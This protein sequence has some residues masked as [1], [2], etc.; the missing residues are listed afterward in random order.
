MGQNKTEFTQ[1][2]SD[3][4]VG[5]AVPCLGNFIDFSVEDK[6]D[7]TVENENESD[8]KMCAYKILMS[9][10]NKAII[11]VSIQVLNE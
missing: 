7:E 1:V 9:A 11:I 4:S 10:A 5:E 8:T 3:I 6:T 2:S